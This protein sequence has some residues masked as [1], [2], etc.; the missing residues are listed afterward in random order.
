MSTKRTAKKKPATKAEYWIIDT[1]VPGMSVGEF[2]ASGPYP[3]QEAAE[4]H[5][6]T[7][8][9]AL[10]SES[11]NCLQSSSDVPWAKPCHIVKVIRTVK[12][13][14]TAICALKTVED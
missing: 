3:T 11:C 6:R 1:D 13:E 8:A 12:V 14:F 2:S 7:E 9:I 4:R 5:I 10:W